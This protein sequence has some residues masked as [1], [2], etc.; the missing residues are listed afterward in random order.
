VELGLSER[1]RRAGVEDA[2]R[3]AL[4]GFVLPIWIGAGIADWWCHRRTD[5]EHTA[6]TTESAIHAAMMIEGGVPAMLGLFC[7]VNAGV[8]ALTYGTLA[9]HELTAVWDVAYADGR[10]DVTPTEQH[11]HGFLERVPLMATVLLTVLHWDQAR[12]VFGAGGRP[13]RQIRL[14]RRPLSV[15]YRMG[16][17]AAVTALVAVPYGEELVRCLRTDGR[18]QPTA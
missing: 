18:A 7:E 12:S 5:I 8:L 17:L 6:G 2:T 3:R 10:R 9:A 1:R 16:V 13:D 14:K 4:Q 11:V 15:R